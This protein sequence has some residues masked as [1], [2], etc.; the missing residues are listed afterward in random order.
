MKKRT[1]FDRQIECRDRAIEQVNRV[2]D[3]AIKSQITHGEIL[4]TLA[5]SV[6]TENAEITIRGKKVS[7]LVRVNGN[8]VYKNHTP[9]F[10]QTAEELYRELVI[11]LTNEDGE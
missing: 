1:E 2:F 10:G 5:A 7:T 11:E 8:P 6:Y 4:A 9:R 3:E